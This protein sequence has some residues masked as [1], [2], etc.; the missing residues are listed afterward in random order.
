MPGITVLINGAQSTEYNISRA[1]YLQLESN[2][3]KC[4]ELLIEDFECL[5]L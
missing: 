3:L 5:S 2:D 1:I 4:H